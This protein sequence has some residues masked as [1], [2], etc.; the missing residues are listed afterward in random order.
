MN[1]LIVLEVVSL[2]LVGSLGSTALAADEE[3]PAQEAIKEA[4]NILEARKARTE[5]KGD[6]D[7][8]AD[9]IAALQKLLPTK[10]AGDG[11]KITPAILRK[12]FQGKASYN[13]KT[14]LLTLVYDF[15]STDQ[16]KD[17][18][19]DDS[20]PQVAKRKVK[21]D[22][23]EVMRHAVK[24]KTVTINA[25]CANRRGNNHPLIATTER[26][27]F[28]IAG[29]KT[30]LHFQG[31]DVVEN[32]LPRGNL[33]PVELK[34]M[35]RRISLKAGDISLGKAVKT[36]GAGQVE[37]KGGEKGN[38]FSSVVLEGKMDEEWAKKFFAP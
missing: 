35:E 24:W 34:V 12:K 3:S 7:K 26:Y 10:A 31:N 18:E 9:A 14:G 16:L 6:Q 1:R 33:W 21:L 2:F 25:Q 17:F 11:K 23:G 30:A 20:K 36:D 13:S 15:S 22:G 32:R 4:I 29:D 28:W 37:L 5:K 8:I 27:A 38:T 19:L